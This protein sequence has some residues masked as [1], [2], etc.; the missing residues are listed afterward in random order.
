M[1][2]LHVE[3]IQKKTPKIPKSEKLGLPQNWNIKKI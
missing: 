2:M 3:N 1:K